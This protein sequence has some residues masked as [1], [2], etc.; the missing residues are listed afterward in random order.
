MAAPPV[1]KFI[2]VASTKPELSGAIADTLETG[3]NV[4][5]IE[6]TVSQLGTAKNLATQAY[7]KVKS[8][9]PP[10]FETIKGKIIPSSPEIMNR[11]ARLKPTDST[12]FEKM[13]GMTQ[14]EYLTKTGNFGAPDKIIANEST[15]FAKSI[16]DVDN[17]LAKLP[18]IYRDGAV[19]DAL[20]GLLEKSRKVSSENIKS[21]Y[22]NQVKEWITKYNAGGL[23][24][25]DI[26]QVKRLFER[27]VKLGYNKLV[28]GP[29][30]ER[31]TYIDSAL[32]NW[33][34][35]Q[36]NTLGFKNIAELNKQTQ[37]SK[38]LIDKLGDQVIGQSGLNGVSLTDWIMLSGG[39]ATAITGFLTKKFFSNK[40]VQAKVAEMLNKEG[41]KGQV[42]PDIGPSQVKQLPA[43]E[44]GSPQSSV[45]VPINM[46]TRGM[47]ER[48]T[49]VVPRTS[50]Q[51]P[52]QSQQ[53]IKLPSSNPTTAKP[54][55]KPVIPNQLAQEA[56][57]YKSAEEF[58]KAQPN[59][60]EYS[61][62][63]EKN[64][65]RSIKNLNE[66][67]INVKNGEDIITLYHGTNAKGVK[68]I[69]ESGTLNP[70][71]YLATDK[72]ASKGFVFGKG[73]NVLE[74][75]VPVK[76]AGFVQTP[77]AGA[78]GAT[79]QNPVRLVKGEDGVWRAEQWKSK[80]ELE[81]IWKS[82][83]K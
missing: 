55:V 15:K 83:N 43:P 50:T 6:G 46:P 13:T 36:A 30:V 68:G 32:R 76:D 10:A 67:G 22:H 16:A 60:A 7:G 82:A 61:P 41:I 78:K 11:V 3:L 70:F 51:T 73:G 38:F 62:L 80:S 14:G 23:T 40:S 20:K 12:K 71:S 57:K 47:L 56:K 54:T 9:V 52:P 31:A 33:Q 79:I 64:V 44:A 1:Q 63:D 74:I 18:G 81:E 34:V 37:A 2:D 35:K 48:G 17:E 72:N 49:E 24:M 19:S 26:N 45:N 39:D 21:P 4:A 5:G 8:V 42:R 27:E 29:A 69:T 58:V 75:K 77:M 66:V 53:T 59:I 28:D 25:S 65:A